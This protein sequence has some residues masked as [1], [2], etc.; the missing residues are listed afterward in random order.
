MFKKIQKWT[1]CYFIAW[2]LIILFGSKG[3]KKLVEWWIEEMKK[4]EN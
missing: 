2:G 3:A 4:N 1:G